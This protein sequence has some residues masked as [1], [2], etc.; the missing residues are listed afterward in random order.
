VEAFVDG[1]VVDIDVDDL[2][3]DDVAPGGLAWVGADDLEGLALEGD[4]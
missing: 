2:A 4:G 1:G 3:E